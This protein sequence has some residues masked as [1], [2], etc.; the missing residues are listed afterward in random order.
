MGEAYVRGGE[1]SDEATRDHSVWRSPQRVG[2]LTVLLIAAG[3]A[4]AQA[5]SFGWSTLHVERDTMD[6]VGT[7]NCMVFASAYGAAALTIEFDTGEENDGSTGHP[8]CTYDANLENTELKNYM[9][10]WKGST[11]ED[12]YWCVMISSAYCGPANQD[13]SPTSEPALLGITYNYEYS[14]AFHETIRRYCV[15]YNTSVLLTSKVLA[16]HETGHQFNPPKQDTSHACVMSDSSSNRTTSFC[17]DETP[18]VSS[19]LDYV[20]QGGD[21]AGH[22]GP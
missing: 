10:K 19:C 7:P 15:Y 14:W 4:L 3:L 5:P 11:S 16:L 20:K 22:P 12:Q 9:E 8:R 17:T 1:V 13:F 2:T 21:P 6:S 18:A